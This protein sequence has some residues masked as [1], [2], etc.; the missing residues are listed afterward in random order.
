[1]L[2]RG[3]RIA[4]RAKVNDASISGLTIVDSILP[5]G[6]GQRQLILPSSTLSFPNTNVIILLLNFI[7]LISMQIYEQLFLEYIELPLILYIMYTSGILT[8]F[9][10]NGMVCF[11]LSLLS[12]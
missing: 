1:M 3:S 10:V 12:S 2:K 7:A 8:M 6:K 5:V 9:V 4:L 11:A